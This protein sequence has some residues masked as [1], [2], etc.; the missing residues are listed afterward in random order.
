MSG[1]PI[2]ITGCARSGT[3]MVAGAL[4]AS[5]LNFGAP[6]YL[7][8]KKGPNQ[9][10]G[11]I[12]HKRVKKVIVKPLLKSMGADPLGQHPLPPRRVISTVDDGMWVRRTL[13]GLLDPGR[14]YKD[15][16]LLL[17]WP[18][19]RQAFPAAQWIIVRRDRMAIAESCERT[20]F[21][22]KRQGVGAWLDW[23][24]DH[25]QRIEDLKGSGVSYC[26]VWPDPARMEPWRDV[27]EFAGLAWNE[28]AVRRA[29]VPGAWQGNG[30]AP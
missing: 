3:S 5:G 7:N 11:F 30:G 6:R 9:P 28:D 21:M 12:E 2:L 29:L 25:L 15:A 24:D 26:E 8:L 14:A 16:K 4:A 27:V 22:R 13:P 1:Q 20:S 19:F 10:R 18:I 23:V 17:L